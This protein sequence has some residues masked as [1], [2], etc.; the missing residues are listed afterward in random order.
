M[1]DG[2]FD[3]GICGRD[4]IEETSSDVVSLGEMTYSKATT[5][6][7]RIVVAVPETRS[8]SRSPTSPTA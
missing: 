2:L 7:V 8:T 5:N 3:L 6:P 1:S 4:W